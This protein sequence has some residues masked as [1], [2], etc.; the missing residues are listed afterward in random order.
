ME[1]SFRPK[2][3]QTTA[4][5]VVQSRT[6]SITDG[7]N[8]DRTITAANHLFLFDSA[9]ARRAEKTEKQFLSAIDRFCKS[10]DAPLN[11]NFPIISKIA[12]AHTFDTQLGW[13]RSM[14]ME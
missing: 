1:T 9:Y 6:M 12:W 7:G 5:R 11:D 10:P 4:R 2:R 3:S 14:S 13:E 8:A